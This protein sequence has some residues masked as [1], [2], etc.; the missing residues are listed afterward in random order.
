MKVL[1]LG[2]I[3]CEW[4]IVEKDG[5][6]LKGSIFARDTEVSPEPHCFV[7][8][9]SFNVQNV[10][11]VGQIREVLVPEAGSENV[12]S[13]II[14]LDRFSISEVL[15]PDFGMPVLQ[16][17]ADAALQTTTVLAAASY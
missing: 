5:L 3:A 12:P 13:G 14:T 11:V 16:K 1:H 2:G 17:P 9:N 8:S 6:R 15:H 7:I 4:Y 10:L